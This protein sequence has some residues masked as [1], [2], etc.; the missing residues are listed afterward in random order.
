MFNND[1]FNDDKV[2]CDN[3][4]DKVEV[5]E[6]YQLDIDMYIFKEFEQNVDGDW[7]FFILDKEGNFEG[8]YIVIFDGEVIKYDEN[9][10]EIE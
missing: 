8:F 3:V 4:I 6:G 1:V 7:G 9:G 2:I 5:Y 10:E